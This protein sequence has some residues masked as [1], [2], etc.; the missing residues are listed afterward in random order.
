M[1]Y[2]GTAKKISDNHNL[3]PASKPMSIIT[4]DCIKIIYCL[5]D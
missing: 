3:S 4:L 1:R 2:G 5:N